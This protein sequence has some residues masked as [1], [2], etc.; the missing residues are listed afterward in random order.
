VRLAGRNLAIN[1]QDLYLSLFSNECKAQKMSFTDS[2]WT[3]IILQAYLTGGTFNHS[4][5][6]AVHEISHNMAFGIKRPL[7]VSEKD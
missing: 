3:L 7:A 1:Q 6:L 4:L 2:D 5:T